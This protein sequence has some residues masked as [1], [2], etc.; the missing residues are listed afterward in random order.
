MDSEVGIGVNQ[1]NRNKLE[2]RVVVR[3]RCNSFRNHLHLFLK[4]AYDLVFN[5]DI[6]VALLFCYLHGFLHRPSFLCSFSL[7][8][9]KAR[10]VSFLRKILWTKTTFNSRL[11]ICLKI[12]P[13]AGRQR[14]SCRPV[15]AQRQPPRCR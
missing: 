4:V 7:G 6:Y 13:E 8:T 2:N 14:D 5:D 15:R 10:T 12:L 11:H 1:I 3:G 9:K